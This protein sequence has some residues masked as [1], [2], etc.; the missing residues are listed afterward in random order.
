VPAAVLILG[1]N[2]AWSSGEGFSLTH[3]YGSGYKLPFRNPFVI[4]FEWLTNSFFTLNFLAAFALVVIIFWLLFYKHLTI[5]LHIVMAY[6]IIIPMCYTL[7]GMPRMMLVAFPVFVLISSVALR[8]KARNI[9]LIVLTL[10]QGYL[11]VCWN[12]SFG[13]VV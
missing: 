2:N 1:M 11:F 5:S 9:F 13:N 7:S 4:I 6:S 3:F 8:Y 12:F 10:W